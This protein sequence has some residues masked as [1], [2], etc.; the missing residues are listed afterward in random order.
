ML[1]GEMLDETL[2]TPVQGRIQSRE[3][4]LV[5]LSHC[6]LNLCQVHALVE[7]VHV[8]KRAIE[9]PQVRTL[10]ACLQGRVAAVGVEVALV[11]V[12]QLLLHSKQD[13]R[14][15]GIAGEVVVL[16]GVNL[17]VVEAPTRATVTSHCKFILHSGVVTDVQGYSEE[18]HV[19]EQGTVCAQIF[20]DAAVRV[21]WCCVKAVRLLIRD[22]LVRP[23][24]QGILAQVQ[25]V[26]A[27]VGSPNNVLP[28]RTAVDGR[29]QRQA[30]VG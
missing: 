29:Q 3:L 19:R 23:P 4:L 30:L 26:R 14:V 25:G 17:N 20:L 5:C 1:L 24:Q 28:L 15:Q 18:V 13:L 9:A 6:H 22:K 7:A 21:H 8:Q 2:E 27:S 12:I 11:Q 16:A 10:Q